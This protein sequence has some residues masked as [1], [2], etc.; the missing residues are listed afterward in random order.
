MPLAP[1]LSPDPRAS[2]RRN[3]RAGLLLWA[4]ALVAILFAVFDAVEDLAGAEWLPFNVADWLQLAAVVLLLAVLAVVVVRDRRTQGRLEAALAD[5]ATDELTGLANRRAFRLAVEREVARAARH[6][7]RFA[8]VLSDLNGLKTLNDRQ[9][10]LAGDRALKEFAAAL[11]RSVRAQDLPARVGGDEFATLL[12]DASREGAE[13]IEGR[14]EEALGSGTR[15]GGLSAAFGLAVYPEDGLTWEALFAAADRRM[16]RD[17]LA[18]L[19][20]GPP[21]VGG[22]FPAATPDAVT[23]PERQ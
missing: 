3:R 11:V 2:N 13:A 6:Q 15:G 20:P 18:S 12:P 17:K 5:A 14:V 21:G 10:H 19:L 7:G 22:A 9:G 1:G 23:P 4:L 16:Y 8:I